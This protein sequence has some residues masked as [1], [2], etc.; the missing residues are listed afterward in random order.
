MK[1]LSDK[2]IEPILSFEGGSK[3]IS[4][5]DMRYYEKDVK[6]SLNEFIEYLEMKTHRGGAPSLIRKKAIEIFGSRVVKR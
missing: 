3:I 4:A 5:N 2:A 1:T 6:K